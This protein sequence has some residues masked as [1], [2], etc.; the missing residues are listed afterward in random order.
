MTTVSA[1]CRL[2]PRPPALVLSRKMKYWDPSSLNFFS[3]NARSSDLV[4]PITPNTDHLE[5]LSSLLWKVCLNFLLG[6]WSKANCCQESKNATSLLWLISEQLNSFTGVW[7][8]HVVDLIKQVQNVMEAANKM[9][10]LFLSDM[11]SASLWSE[12]LKGG[13][14]LDQQISLLQVQDFI[15]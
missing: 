11:L 15:F 14:M 7:K 9:L 4:V 5:M 10:K 12:S 13:V 6:F 8:G 2:R 1:A 3:S